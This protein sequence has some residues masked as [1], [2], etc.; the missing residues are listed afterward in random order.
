LPIF[1]PGAI[2][3]MIRAVLFDAVGTLL[4]ARP[5]VADAYF[6]AG[7]QFGSTL[8]RDE[9]ARR[10]R[11]CWIDEHQHA[12]TEHAWQR[13]VTNQHAER[14]RWRRVVQRVFHELV[15]SAASE[16]LFE[17]LWHHFSS[18]EHWVLFDDVAPIWQSL[19][20]AG[21]VVGIASNFDDRLRT[22]CAGLPPLADCRNVFDSAS[23]GFSKPDSRFFRGVQRRLGLSACE[24]VMVGDDPIHDVQGARQVDWQA[25]HLD[26]TG[27]SRDR[28]ALR[29]LGELLPRLTS[30]GP[31]VGGVVSVADHHDRT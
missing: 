5:A 27:R 14:E 9:V 30:S 25:F 10:F 7:R 8:S 28:S 22:V 20:A 13:P 4:E 24:I 19:T 17:H 11:Q 1:G 3:S 29:S 12:T 2:E 18:S 21:Y 31:A 23:I 16:Q 6:Q 26:R 15:K